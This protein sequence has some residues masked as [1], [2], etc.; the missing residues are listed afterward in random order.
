MSVTI[1][2]DEN[3]FAKIYQKYLMSKNHAVVVLRLQFIY[4][5]ERELSN[6]KCHV[7]CVII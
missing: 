2:T 7:T 6:V 1:L 5:V 4:A 3:V